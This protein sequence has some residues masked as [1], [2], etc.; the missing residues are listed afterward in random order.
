MYIV[1]Y[2]VCNNLAPHVIANLIRDF[3][4]IVTNFATHA[5]KGAIGSG[6]RVVFIPYLDKKSGNRT[7]LM[8]FICI[9]N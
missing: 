7:K 3:F 2:G 4:S 9:L 6:K 8:K 1:Y 5:G